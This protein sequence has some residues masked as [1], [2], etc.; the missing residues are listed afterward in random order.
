MWISDLQNKIDSELGTSIITNQIGTLYCGDC[1]DI[2]E[3]KT[4]VILIG[5]G[6]GFTV[7]M[8]LLCVYWHNL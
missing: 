5:K 6:T 7:L 3:R 2:S 4:S 1:L 8:L